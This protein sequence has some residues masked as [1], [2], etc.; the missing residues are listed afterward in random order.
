MQTEAGMSPPLPGRP[1]KLA[2][3][4][5]CAQR[6]TAGQ[7]EKQTSLFFRLT[8]GFSYARKLS[9]RRS[10]DRRKLFVFAPKPHRPPASLQLSSPGRKRVSSPS[11][12]CLDG[13]PYYRPGLTASP[14]QRLFCWL[15]R[16]VEISRPAAL[17]VPRSSMARSTFLIRLILSHSRLD[18]T[19]VS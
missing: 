10:S 19:A 15:Y 17:S 12:H 3:L 6:K 18:S 2:L 9:W 14:G 16:M 7:A 5:A 4:C 1:A 13:K 8:C 11:Q